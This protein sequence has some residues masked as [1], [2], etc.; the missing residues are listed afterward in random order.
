MQ[1]KHLVVWQVYSSHSRPEAYEVY[2]NVAHTLK[3]DPSVTA[4]LIINAEGAH[5][6]GSH[7]KPLFW[8]GDNVMSQEIGYANEIETNLLDSPH[9]SRVLKL[10]LSFY[11]PSPRQLL[12]TFL[13]RN[14]GEAIIP[15]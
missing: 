5:E 8:Q 12:D 4:L 11:H 2:S 9:C 14:E 15:V 7:G 1:T 6:K 13:G 3:N 10:F